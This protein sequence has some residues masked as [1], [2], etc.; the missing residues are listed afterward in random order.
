LQFVATALCC[1]VLGKEDAPTTDWKEI[2]CAQHSPEGDRRSAKWGDYN[3]GVLNVLFSTAPP[4][5]EVFLQLSEMRPA[6]SKA[7]EFS[8]LVANRLYTLEG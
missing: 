4:L 8:S 5:E 3:V 7:R 2:A 6:F 1:R